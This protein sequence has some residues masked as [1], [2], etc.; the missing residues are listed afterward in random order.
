MEDVLRIA[1]GELLEDNITSS[2]REIAAQIDL[3][4]SASAKGYNL[5]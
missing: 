2:I 4:Y 1:A 3:P 5:F